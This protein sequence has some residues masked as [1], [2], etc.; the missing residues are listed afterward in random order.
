MNRVAMVELATQAHAML[1]RSHFLDAIAM[2]LVVG[3]CASCGGSDGGGGKSTP[4]KSTEVTPEAG[5]P[6]T[7]KGDLVDD[8]SVYT[9]DPLSLVRIDVTTAD[10]AGLAKI[11]GGDAAAKI[12]VAFKEGALDA[13][14]SMELRG[15]TSKLADQKSFKVTLKGQGRWRD[16]KVL[17]LNKHPWELSRVRNKLA[18]D[19]LTTVPHMAS[20][21][22]SFVHLYVNGEDYGLFTQ[23]EQP[24]E[25]YL[26][27]HGFDPNA[28]LYKAADFTFDPIDAATAANEPEF[29]KRLEIKGKPRT[30]DKLRAMLDA[31]NDERQDIDTVITQHFNR[32][33][34]LAWLAFN[35]VATNADT[36]SQNYFLYSP[37]TTS[38]WYF[39]PWDYD[40]ALTWRRSEA[41]T[42]ESRSR[43]GVQNWWEV[44]LHRRFLAKAANAQALDARV[45]ELEAAITPA[46][47]QALLDAY[48][49]LVRPV[50]TAIPDVDHLPSSA[51]TAGAISSHDED[52][53]A[54]AKSVELGVQAYVDALERPMP[55]WIDDPSIVGGTQVRIT[56][57]DS[58]DLQRDA[59]TYD[60]SIAGKPDF[61]ARD[62]LFSKDGLTEPTINFEKPPTGT[63]YVRVIA[64]DAKSPSNHWQNAYD[65]YTDATTG[66]EFFGVKGVAIP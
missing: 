11:N 2:S 16:Q 40:D 66:K 47:I 25:D 54:L 55:F 26:S 4:A 39:L 51:G 24:N 18:F 28:W 21:R 59:I 33:N 64:R 50:V 3:A 62:V 29:E 45:R 57:D 42:A 9:K 17:N 41:A 61:G 31:V 53:K 7:W 36:V 37:T 13:K 19:L 14:A 32:N 8:R 43:E 5:P 12:D 23:V 63:Y 22:T 52:F 1:R 35:V 30:H 38:E 56:W 58:F 65:D 27:T 6:R 46:K 15:A 49:P 10:A 44:T 20:L 48:E 34:Y 60:V